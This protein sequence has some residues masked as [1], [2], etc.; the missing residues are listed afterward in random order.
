LKLLKS[1]KYRKSEASRLGGKPRGGWAKPRGRLSRPAAALEQAPLLAAMAA[2]AGQKAGF[3]TP[4]HQKGRGLWPAF[5]QLLAQWGPALDLTELPGLDVLGAPAGCI[6][7]S[8]NAMAALTGAAATFYLVNGA[9]AGAEAAILALSG[10]GSR[11][12]VPAHAHIS[13]YHGLV[14]SGGHPLILPCEIDEEWGLPLSAAPEPADWAAWA[15]YA[16]AG[17]EEPPAV[18]Q[19]KSGGNLWI[20]VNPTYHGIGADLA[21]VRA[22]LDQ[23]PGCRWLVDEAHGVHLPFL[24]PVTAGA[25]ATGAGPAPSVGAASSAGSPAPSAGPAPAAAA[26]PALGAGSALRWQAQAVAQ[27]AHKLGG[28]FTQTGLLHCG[29]RRLAKDFRQAINILQSSSPSY[30]LLASLDAWQAFLRDDGRRRLALAR[31]L[32]LELAA[33][34]RGIGGYRL[35]QDELPPGTVWDPCKLTLSG[36]ELGLSG[37]QLAELLGRDFGIDTELAADAYVLLLITLG[38]TRRDI[39]R[40]AQ[41]LLAISDRYSRRGRLKEELRAKDGQGQ[42]NGWG[43]KNGRVP[44]EGR[45]LATAPLSAYQAGIAAWYRGEQKIL[46]PELSPREVFFRPGQW[47]PLREAAGRLAAAAVVPYPPGIPLIYPGCRIGKTALEALILGQKAGQAYIG[48]EK[49]GEK[50]FIYVSAE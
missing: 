25:A 17:R 16:P 45:A 39:R 26:S 15:A 8:Q 24:S 10:P 23:R 46:Q 47:V 29:D 34:I 44:R 35:W 28:G 1:R 33:A 12:F 2:R 27:S 6:E 42:K 48:L 20:T 14:L 7:E 40:L 32:A 3:H 18:G 49:R 31:E 9:T 30:L 43:Q 50:S 38:H 21:G 4:G 36:R 41:A 19:G 13:V 5:A 22:A 11:V 37:F